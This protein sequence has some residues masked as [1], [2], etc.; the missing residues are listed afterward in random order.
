M[1]PGLLI[2]P[3]S[4]GDVGPVLHLSGSR[5]T[6]LMML[7]HSP[8]PGCV[9]HGPPFLPR[10][11]FQPQER[12][13][14]SEFVKSEPEARDFGKSVEGSAG[15]GGVLGSRCDVGPGDFP[16]RDLP[17][18]EGTGTLDGIILV[19]DEVLCPD[20]WSWHKTVFRIPHYSYQ[21]STLIQTICGLVRS[22]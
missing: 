10:D 16:M 9:T 1:K 7:P 3:G 11:H 6:H 8:F 19:E 4:G 21:G 20:G 15:G 13:R 5:P 22:D 18:L 2:L 14:K 17:R 12:P